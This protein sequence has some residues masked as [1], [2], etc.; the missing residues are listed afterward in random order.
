[1]TEQKPVQPVEAWAV[2]DKDDTIIS[3]RCEVS[4]EFAKGYANGCDKLFPEDAPHRVIRVV[5]TPK[6]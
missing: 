1:M 3:V 5:I 4:G 2:V 6:E